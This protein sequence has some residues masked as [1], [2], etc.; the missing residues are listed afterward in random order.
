MS[1]RRALSRLVCVC[2]FVHVGV[3]WCV[4]V[5]LR[6]CVFRCVGGTAFCLILYLCCYYL[7][8][9]F[10]ILLFHFLSFIIFFYFWAFDRDFVLSLLHFEFFSPNISQSRLRNISFLVFLV[11]R[12]TNL[13]QLVHW[14]SQS[15][16]ASVL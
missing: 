16:V 6:A 14:L 1:L 2:R 3:C 15:T 4:C 11:F 10:N 9:C 7:T 13:N 12:H 8:A 5:C